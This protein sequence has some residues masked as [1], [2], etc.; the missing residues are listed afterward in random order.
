M[1]LS[2]LTSV[3]NMYGGRKHQL[4]CIR[5]GDCKGL[6]W[7]EKRDSQKDFVLCKKLICT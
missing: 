4:T 3:L 2:C 1:V 7:E 5:K 6:N